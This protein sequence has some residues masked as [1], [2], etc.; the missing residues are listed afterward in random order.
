MCT[1]ELCKIKS[2]YFDYRIWLPLSILQCL[3]NSVGTAPFVYTVTHFT[4]TMN[5]INYNT[6]N[7]IT[8]CIYEQ[9]H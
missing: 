3:F 7:I 1:V 6:N 9:L 8:E 5:A 4:V 2:M